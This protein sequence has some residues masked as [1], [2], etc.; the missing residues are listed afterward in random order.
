MKGNGTNQLTNDGESVIGQRVGNLPEHSWIH[1]EGIKK[2]LK[3]RLQ[4]SVQRLAF[5]DFSLDCCLEVGSQ[6]LIR[7]QQIKLMQ[8]EKEVW[9]RSARLPDLGQ[10][11]GSFRSV[12]G[13]RVGIAD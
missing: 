3:S 9:V 13:K 10:K 1:H 12:G 5:T 4:S 2:S 8:P 11:F 7:F 6:V